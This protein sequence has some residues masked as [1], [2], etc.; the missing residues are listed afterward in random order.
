M[1]AL[2]PKAAQLRSACRI[3]CPDGH[4]GD[5]LKS[6]KVQ[7]DPYFEDAQLKHCPDFARRTHSD[8][9]LV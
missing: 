8:A 6:L 3:P 1:T 2:V 4:E 9:V 5:G 7:Y